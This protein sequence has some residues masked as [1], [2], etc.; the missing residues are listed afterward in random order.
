MMI[1][2]KSMIIDSKDITS[3]EI[4]ENL[5]DIADRGEPFIV[6]HNGKL[7]K[8]VR[9]TEEEERLYQDELEKA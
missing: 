9:L 2:D 3:D 7:Y 5:F 4:L 1:S 6:R 8:F